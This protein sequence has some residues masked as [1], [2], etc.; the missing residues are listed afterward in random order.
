MVAAATQRAARENQVAGELVRRGAAVLK[1][2][3]SWAA[4][5]AVSLKC[6]A[7]QAGKGESALVECGALWAGTCSSEVALT[8]AMCGVVQR[9]RQQW[10]GSGEEA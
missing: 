8:V 5:A 2:S 10:R 7:L 3:S 4:A 6:E 9:S 1:C